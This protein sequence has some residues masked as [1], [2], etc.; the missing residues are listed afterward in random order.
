ML[1]QSVYGDD[2]QITITF[3]S[4]ANSKTAPSDCHIYFPKFVGGWEYIPA[5]L[6]V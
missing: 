6:K 5:G 3:I 4:T 1:F 2:N